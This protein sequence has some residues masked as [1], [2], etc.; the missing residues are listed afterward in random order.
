[1]QTIFAVSLPKPLLRGQ[2]TDLI[3]N[4]QVTFGVL[5]RT[6]HLEPGGA[7][8]TRRDVYESALS[9]LTSRKNANQK[10]HASVQLMI[11]LRVILQV[12]SSS[13]QPSLNPEN[14]VLY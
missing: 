1:M 3:D 7:T 14:L 12:I 4:V 8:A 6:G 11:E 5:E 10:R 9:R 13:S 2:E